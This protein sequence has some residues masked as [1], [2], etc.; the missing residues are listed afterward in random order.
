VSDPYDLERFVRAQE[1]LYGRVRQELAGGRKRS[2]WMWFIFPQLAGLG[3]SAMARQYAIASLAEARAYLQH[4]LLGAR[5]IECTALVN[6]CSG[7]TVETIFGYPD[8][9][10]F[11]SCMTLFARAQADGSDGSPF[12]AALE[13]YCAG[14]EDPRTRALLTSACGTSE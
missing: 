5:L 9:L 2:H 8:D 14:A 3:S 7:K 10:K 1:P 6:A 11:R 12:R 4:P 13:K